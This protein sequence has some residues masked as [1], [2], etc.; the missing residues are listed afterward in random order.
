MQSLLA[1][2]PA[3]NGLVFSEGG[4][5]ALARHI[6]KGYFDEPI[7]YSFL[8]STINNLGEKSKRVFQ[9]FFTL[10]VTSN[11]IGVIERYYKKT[12]TYQKF[13]S[14]D[15]F[16]ILHVIRNGLAHDSIWSHHKYKDKLPITHNGITYSMDLNDKPMHLDYCDFTIVWKL[17][18]DLKSFIENDIEE[19]DNAKL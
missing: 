14:N 7:D 17:V 1:W 6:D 19:L 15:V 16:V 13:W 10:Y 5:T 2:Y 12:K 4:L 8:T 3:V 9:I 11:V 18:K